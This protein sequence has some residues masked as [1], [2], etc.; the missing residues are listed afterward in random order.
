MAITNQD[1][2]GNFSGTQS[3]TFFSCSNPAD[4]SS[5]TG[6]YSTNGSGLNGNLYDINGS[7]SASLD[8]STITFT[9]LGLISGNTVTNSGNGTLT[10]AAGVNF[11][12]FTFT[13]TFTDA[14]TLTGTSSGS[15]FTGVGSDSCSFTST[16]SASRNG[17]IINP[18]TSASSSVTTTATSV[19]A[20]VVTITSD[21][22]GRIQNALSGLQG[23]GGARKTASGAMY[24]STLGLSAGDVVIPFGVWSSFSYSDFENDFTTTAFEGDRK[25]ILAGID[26]FPWDKMVLGIAFGY[27]FSDI[28]TNFNRGETEADGFTVAP[29]FGAIINDVWSIDASFGYSSLETDQF[30]TIGTATVVTSSLDTDRWFG[31]F[32]FNGNKYYGDWLFGIRAGVIIARNSQDAFT[33][34]DGTRVSERNTELNNWNFGGNVSYFYKSFEPFASFTYHHD[35]RFTKTTL[36]TGAQPANDDDDVVAALGFRY[37]V[38]DTITSNFEYSKRISRDNFEEDTFNFTIRGE[39]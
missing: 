13:T 39:F 16:Y 7:T 11:G 5:R 6:S 8:G 23:G 34:S 3:S 36:A 37:F 22:G 4:N 24:D 28:D 33:E 18:E 35:F 32:N 20:E 27:E 10:S 17:D 29:Y 2:L 9:V 31:A 15:F 1:V 19:Q 26:F 14:D 12:T 21:L 38:T 25:N 30:R